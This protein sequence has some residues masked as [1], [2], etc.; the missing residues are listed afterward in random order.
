LTSWSN[1]TTTTNPLTVPLLFFYRTVRSFSADP[2][3][4][5][6]LRVLLLLF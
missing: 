4:L 5:L 1:T 2:T 3:H 6:I